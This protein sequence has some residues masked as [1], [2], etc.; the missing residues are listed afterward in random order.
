[1]KAYVI[2]I[3]SSFKDGSQMVRYQEVDELATDTDIEM[4]VPDNVN[5]VLTFKKPILSKVS[6]K[7]KH[8]G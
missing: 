8:Y 7:M 3:D 5:W 6:G 1:M 4:Q 2:W